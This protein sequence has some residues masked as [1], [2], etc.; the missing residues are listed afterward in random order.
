SNW[1]RSGGNILADRYLDIWRNSKEF[2]G[3]R[4]VTRR[5]FTGCTSCG[6][7]GDC[8]PCAAMNLNENGSVA[9]PSR[10]VC[11]DT[12]AVTT[13]KYGA[14]KQLRMQRQAVPGHARLPVLART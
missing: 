14:S 11:D 7:Q 9:E 12:A 3:A 6:D 2:A 8:H 1:P 10:T 13:V 5:S 4:A